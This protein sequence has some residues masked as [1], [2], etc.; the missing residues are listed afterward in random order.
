M[1]HNANDS[2]GRPSGGG[3]QTR[4]MAVTGTRRTTRDKPATPRGSRG[5]RGPAS[6]SKATPKDAEAT[7]ASGSAKA[8]AFTPEPVSVEGLGE[9]VRSRRHRTARATVAAPTVKAAPAV[10][11]KARRAPR[12]PD[13]SSEGAD[14]QSEAEMGAGE[15]LPA[16][17]TA[18]ETDVTGQ[19]TSAVV[20]FADTDAAT[21]VPDRLLGRDPSSRPH[22]LPFPLHR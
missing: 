13:K 3:V 1:D 7:G 2:Q 9:P 14:K 17:C 6:V 18:R 4:S 19:G 16:P 15:T 5:S 8:K 21:A 11:A 12:G 22:F 10:G 20:H